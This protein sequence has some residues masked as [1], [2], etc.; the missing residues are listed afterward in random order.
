LLID[1][2]EPELLAPAKYPK[3][4]ATGQPGAR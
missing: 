3:V 1:R 4:K 2:F